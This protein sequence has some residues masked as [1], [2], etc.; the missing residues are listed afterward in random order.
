MDEHNHQKIVIAAIRRDFPDL[1][2]FAIPNAGTASPQR[3][4]WLKAEGLLAGVP[5]L[6]VAR[7]AQGFLGLFVE[8]KTLTGYASK[9]QKAMIARLQ[10]E[11]YRC[12]V[13]KGYE[14][15]LAVI[16]SY[17]DVTR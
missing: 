17:L 12:E 10:A 9:E 5:D 11:G 2:I 7:A 15:A 3:G 4:A 16:R 1:I 13:C 14:A 6:M 8:M